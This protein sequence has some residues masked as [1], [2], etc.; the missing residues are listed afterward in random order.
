LR[1]WQRRKVPEG[2][3]AGRDATQPE[4]SMR[5]NHDDGA[6]G[7]RENDTFELPNAQSEWLTRSEVEG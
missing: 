5:M 2:Q 1:R 3:T 6:V 7:G 4:V